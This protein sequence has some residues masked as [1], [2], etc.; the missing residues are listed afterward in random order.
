MCLEYELDGKEAALQVPR[1][2]WIQ[3]KSP[4]CLTICLLVFSNGILQDLQAFSCFIHDNIQVYPL[5]SLCILYVV[6]PSFWF[7]FCSAS[8]WHV[9]M[10]WEISTMVVTLYGCCCSW[11]KSIWSNETQSCKRRDAPVGSWTSQMF[12][13]FQPF[14][15]QMMK[16]FVGNA[17]KHVV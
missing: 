12:L 8:P 15:P 4:V 1:F 16:P 3:V 9:W 11:P 2:W 6:V 14:L 13:D 17:L 7:V 10:S 5:E